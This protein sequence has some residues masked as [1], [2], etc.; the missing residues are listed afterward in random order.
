VIVVGVD[1]V[2]FFE[3]VIDAV[4][5]IDFLLGEEKEKGESW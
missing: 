2:A 3:H 5:E 1:F 4:D